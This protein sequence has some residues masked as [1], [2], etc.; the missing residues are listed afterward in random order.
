MPITRIIRKFEKFESQSI[1]DTIKFVEAVSIS[2]I[3]MTDMIASP[4][5]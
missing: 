1:S 2:A 4:S 5:R 3:L